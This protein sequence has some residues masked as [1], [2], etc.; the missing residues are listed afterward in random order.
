MQP[1]NTDVFGF[2]VRVRNSWFPLKPN[3][4]GPTD[5]V[6]VIFCAVPS[7]YIF[8]FIAWLLSSAH[9]RQKVCKHSNLKQAHAIFSWQGALTFWPKTQGTFYEIGNVCRIGTLSRLGTLCRLQTLHS[10]MWKPPD[11]KWSARFLKKWI[12]RWNKLKVCF[13]RLIWFC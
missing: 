13:K 3:S 4:V 1:K 2:S 11:K 6:S 9:R 7:N 12:K 5:T 8:F 10:K